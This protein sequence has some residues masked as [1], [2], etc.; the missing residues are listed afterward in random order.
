MLS[1]SRKDSKKAKVPAIADFISPR[2]EGTTR[3]VAA[4]NIFI[5]GSQPQRN[6]YVGE[7]QHVRKDLLKNQPTIPIQN[8][9]THFLQKKDV[10]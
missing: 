7:R 4:D 1:Q 2:I 9:F 8:I 3:S 5:V 10:L 6:F